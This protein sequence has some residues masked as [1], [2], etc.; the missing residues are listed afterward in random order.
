MRTQLFAVAVAGL[1]LL[2]GCAAPFQGEGPDATETATPMGTTASPSTGTGTASA[3]Y[4]TTPHMGCQPGAIEKNG[5]C[6]PVTSGSNAE[7]F[8][9]ENLSAIT[10]RN[11][12]IDGTPG[13]LARPAAE[14]DY[15]AVVMIHE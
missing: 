13:Y 8:D 4:E 11:A 9:A 14:G 3:A 12:T 5:T 1:V 10:A 15:P 6:Q 7:I 2:S